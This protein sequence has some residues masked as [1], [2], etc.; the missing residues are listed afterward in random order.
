MPT[1]LGLDL[2]GGTEL[3]YQGRPTPQQPTVTG[4]DIDRSIE[5]IRQR[6]DKLGVAEPEISRVGADQ[7]S[8]GLPD[9]DNADRAIEQVGDTAQLY[10]YDW[11]PNVIGAPDTTNPPR[12]RSRAST[13]PSSS[14]PSSRPSCDNC[15][16]AGPRYYLFDKTTQAA[17]RRPREDRSRTCSSTSPATS[18]RPTASSSTVPQGTLVVKGRR[19]NRRATSPIAGI[20]DPRPP[21][22]LGHRHHQPRAELRPEHQPAE[23]HLRLQRRGPPEVRG[24]DQEDRRARPRQRA[25]RAPTRPRSPTISRSSSTTRSSRGRSS[26]TARTRTGSTAA[27]A[28]RSRAT[29]SSTRRRTSP[30]S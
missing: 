19:Q 3:V 15:T 22:A 14:P 5:I 10:F 7:I 11:E 28:P 29:S 12:P 1:K 18:S 17:D 16:T 13:T 27:R 6:T 21:V 24:R 23:R 2:K 20:R 8:V 25:A 9:V 26:T 4:E 30:S